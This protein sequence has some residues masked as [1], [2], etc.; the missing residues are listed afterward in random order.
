L[1]NAH[2]FYPI[3][4]TLHIMAIELFKET[5]RCVTMVTENTKEKTFFPALVHGSP[6]GECDLLQIFFT[7]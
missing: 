6:E 2:L 7:H 5:G 1:C 3:A 4:S